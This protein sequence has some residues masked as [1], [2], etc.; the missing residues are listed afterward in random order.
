MPTVALLG[1]NR[2]GEKVYE[3]LVD[4]DET[5]VLGAFTEESQYSSIRALE[6]DFL[7]SAGFDHIVPDD[8]LDVPKEGAINLHPS[9]LPYNR[10]VNPDVWSI[11]RDEPAG[12]TV[13]YM[14]PEMDAGP[15]VAR[16]KVEVRSTDTGRDLRKRLDRALVELF[17]ENWDDVYTG[18]VDPEPQDADAGTVNRRKDFQEVCELD[19]EAEVRVGDLLDRLRALTFPPYHNAH[20]EKDGTSYYVR[21]AIES[22]ED[23]QFDEFEWDEPTLF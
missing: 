5:E 3:Y 9:Y 18:T 12:V 23:A 4:H 7:I 1:M 10:G 17:T 19:L 15:I 16:R 2:F 8:V 6:P 22:E 13:H 20:F 21:V 14:T 11:I